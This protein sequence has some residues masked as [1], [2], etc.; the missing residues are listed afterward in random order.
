MPITA[1]MLLADSA[2]AV[3]GKLY[4]LG[5]GWNLTTGGIPS[6]VA[7]VI[8]VSWDMANTR[9]DWRLELVDSDDQP[10]VP[11]GQEE[12][13][14]AWGAF[15]AGRPPGLPVGTELISPLAVNIGPL[16]LA[17]GRYVWRLLID[18]E[19]LDSA[20]AAFNVVQPPSPGAPPNREQRRH[21]PR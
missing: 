21:P 4:I 7:V 20:R 11:E 13:V 6:A 2:Q 5:G 9:H 18:G 15:E 8:N 16:P 17:P 3:E 12:A 19:P 10:V 1:T 14:A